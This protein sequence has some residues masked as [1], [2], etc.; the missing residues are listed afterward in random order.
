MAPFTPLQTRKLRLWGLKLPGSF[1]V[2]KDSTPGPCVS[3]P[4]LQGVYTLLPASSYT[5]RSHLHYIRP[6]A[7]KLAGAAWVGRLVC[8][9]PR[10]LA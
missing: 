1:S 5:G 8:L 6:R 7:G 4:R 9:A 3:E 2:D 10:S